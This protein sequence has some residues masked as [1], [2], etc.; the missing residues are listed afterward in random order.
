MIIVPEGKEVEPFFLTAV[1]DNHR[2][3]AVND[4]F[5]ATGVQDLRPE[6]VKDKEIYTF[7]LDDGE[8]SA[9]LT[10]HLYNQYCNTHKI[11]CIPYL[12]EP[13]VARYIVKQKDHPNVSYLHNCEPFI[14]F[15]WSAVDLYYNAIYKVNDF[16][17]GDVLISKYGDYWKVSDSEYEKSRQR[18]VRDLLCSNKVNKVLDIGCYL[19]QLDDLL[20]MNGIQVIRT[21]ISVEAM[22]NNVKV[23]DYRK[24]T[25]EN[26]VEL[27]KDVDC[28]MFASVLYAY[29]D[30]N[31]SNVAKI[32]NAIK[33]SSPKY[34]MYEDSKVNFS[35]GNKWLELFGRMGYSVKDSIML[36]PAIEEFYDNKNIRRLGSI[37]IIMEHY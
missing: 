20:E 35:L 16:H 12:E 24:L 10:Y 28:V 37:S 33:I 2:I 1:S 3:L 8:V 31:D 21:D 36:A 34:I 22:R 32:F 27:C 9:S 25:E 30:E 11:W 18:N 17:I 26:L 23:L 13:E 19:G 4:K 7:G 6:V 15:T 29:E 14:N 5:I